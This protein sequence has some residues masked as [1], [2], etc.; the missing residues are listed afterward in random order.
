MEE[1]VVEKRFKHR[2]STQKTAVGVRYETKSQDWLSILNQ[3]M[4]FL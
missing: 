1:V 2:T 3:T 4:I